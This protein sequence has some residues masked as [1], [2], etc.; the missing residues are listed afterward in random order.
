MISLLQH[1]ATVQG[2]QSYSCQEKRIHQLGFAERSL[3]TSKQACRGSYAR[4]SRGGSEL[5]KKVPMVEGLPRRFNIV[6]HR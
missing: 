3:A 1:S 6:E 4:L 2:T 5:I